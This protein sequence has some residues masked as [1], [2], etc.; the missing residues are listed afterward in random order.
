MMHNVYEQ[1]E[2]KLLRILEKQVNAK[3]KE[4]KDY[5]AYYYIPVTAKYLRVSRDVTKQIEESWGEDE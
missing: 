2:K 4:R 1:N 5:Q 3:I